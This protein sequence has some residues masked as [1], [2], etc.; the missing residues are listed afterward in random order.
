MTAEVLDFTGITKHKLDPDR[1]LSQAL[2][3][4]GTVIVIGYDTDGDLFFASSD[5]DG[6]ECLWLLEKTKKALLDITE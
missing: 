3:K 6:P 1:V 5:P 2:G 4:L